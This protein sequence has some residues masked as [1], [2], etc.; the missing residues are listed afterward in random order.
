[1]T[2]MIEEDREYLKMIKRLLDS[3]NETQIRRLMALATVLLSVVMITVDAVSY[4][5]YRKNLITTEQGQLLTIAQ[6]TAASLDRYLEQELKS[7]DLCF[8]GVPKE[9]DV[10]NPESLNSQIRRLLDSSKGLYRSCVVKPAAAAASWQEEQDKQTEQ[11]EA[12]I[13]SKHLADT[14]WYEMVIS[15]RVETT[16]GPV[17]L[18]LSMDLN[19]VYRKI[20]APVHIGDGGY[21]VVK[22]S[23]LAIIMHHAKSQI[24]MDALYDREEQYPDLDLSS[25][26]EWLELQ[27]RQNEGIGI[28]DSYVW[29]DPELSPVRRIVAYTTID[30]Q[31]EHWI[32]NSTLPIEEV[33]GPL[34]LMLLT[35]AALTALFLLIITLITTAVTRALTLSVAQ[36]KEIEYLKEINRGNELIASKNDEIRHYQRVQS[37]GMMSSH[38]AHEFNNYL[39]PVMVYGEMLLEDEEISED[40]RTML[41][42]MM[43]SVDQAAKLSRELLDFSRMDAGGRNVPLNLT[44]DTEEAAAVL[45]QLV[46]RKIHFSAELSDQPA[47]LMGREGMMQHILMNLG[48]NAF[49]AMEETDDKNLRVSYSVEGDSAVLSISDTGCGIPADKLK[50]IFEPFYTTKGS[51]QGTGLGLSVVRS[52]TENTGGRVEVKSVPGK[53]TTFT[54]RFPVKRDEAQLRAQRRA[55]SANN[56]ICVCQSRESISSWRKWLDSLGAHIEYTSKEAAVAVRMQENASVCDLLILEEELSSMSGIELAQIVRRSNPELLITILARQASAELKRCLD[57]RVIDQIRLP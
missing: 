2:W 44:A 43:K 16:D 39:T 9:G 6:I 50:D 47:W 48:K 56:I 57:N 5:R 21:S 8:G 4:D 31:N 27:R 11:Y 17:T 55:S 34:K 36:K 12:T 32:I 52:L 19:Y 42:E 30:I 46:P 25:L 54:L 1:M 51:S 18:L 49:H 45:R 35:M 23:D 24:G 20:V 15:R 13:I 3:L 37:L 28:L 14:G 29:D 22:D 7:I 53:G 38:I 40:N 33:S 41:G 10:F 26:K